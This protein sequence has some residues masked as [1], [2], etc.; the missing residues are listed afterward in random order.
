MVNFW[1][2]N[3]Y[4][5]VYNVFKDY[6]KINIYKFSNIGICFNYKRLFKENIILL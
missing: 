3:C 2:L 1:C 5:F 6:C 4:Y